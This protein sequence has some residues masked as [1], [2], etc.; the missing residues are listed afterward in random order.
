MAKHTTDLHFATYYIQHD[1]D[2]GALQCDDKSLTQQHFKDECDINN[3]MA[4]YTQ[5]GLLPQGTT[6]TGSYEDF[7]G[8]DNYLDALL[9]IQNAQNQFAELPR[10]TRNRFKNDPAL[11]LEF[12]N[13]TNNKAEAQELGLLNAEPPAPKPPEPPAPKPPQPPKTP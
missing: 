2:L 3:I 5:T 7:A 4:N 9:I 8:P 13:D 6:Q 12:I 11:F 10:D 1:P